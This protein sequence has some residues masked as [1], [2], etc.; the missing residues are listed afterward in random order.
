M[1]SD[2]GLTRKCGMNKSL[3]K[4][5]FFKSII[6][7]RRN[8]QGKIHIFSSSVFAKQSGW[9]VKFWVKLSSVS[10]LSVSRH[11]WLCACTPSSRAW[12]SDRHGRFACHGVWTGGSRYRCGLPTRH[13]GYLHGKLMEHG[14]GEGKILGRL[15]E[16]RGVGRA[17]EEGGVR[18]TL[19]AWGGHWPQMLHR[20]CTL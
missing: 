20:A 9:S 13:W 19:S 18:G 12:W 5:I 4:Q 11:L 2:V 3:Q 7:K 14:S 8:Y 10:F 17:C 15:L 16:L 6:F 1:C